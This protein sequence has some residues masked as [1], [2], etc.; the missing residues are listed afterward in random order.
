MTVKKREWC[1][2]VGKLS[3][4]VLHETG[5]ISGAKQ[6]GILEASSGGVELHCC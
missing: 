1:V 2:D 4:A 6:R 5:D 3:E